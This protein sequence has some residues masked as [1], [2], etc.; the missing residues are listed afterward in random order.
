MTQ[1]VLVDVA[2][3]IMTVTLNRPERK[4]ALSNEAWRPCR[5]DRAR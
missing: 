1:L 3:G 2:D 4:N 5:C